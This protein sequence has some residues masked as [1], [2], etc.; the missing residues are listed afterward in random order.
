MVKENKAEATQLINIYASSVAH[1]CLFFTNTNIKPL[2][3]CDIAM[4][5]ILLSMGIKTTFRACAC[6]EADGLAI[7]ISQAVSNTVILLQLRV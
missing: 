4:F 2:S 1:Q 3:L 6:K 5:I 7:W